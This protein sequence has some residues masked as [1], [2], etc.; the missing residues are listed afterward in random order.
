MEDDVEDDDT[1]IEKGEN[2][3]DT[4]A[5]DKCG[6][7]DSDGGYMVLVR[8]HVLRHPPERTSSSVRSPGVKLHVAWD[9]DLDAPMLF[10]VRNMS[11]GLL[12][13]V[14]HHWR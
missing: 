10:S 14:L 3:S 7:N 13:P 5:D 9:L 2:D 12:H 11:V 1:A 8:P 6:P 4:E